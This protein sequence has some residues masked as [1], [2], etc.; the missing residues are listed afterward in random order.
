MAFGCT[1]TIFSGNSVPASGD[2]IFGRKLCTHKTHNWFSNNYSF[3]QSRILNS[4]KITSFFDRKKNNS[5]WLD[6]S[7]TAKSTTHQQRKEQHTNIMCVCTHKFTH[8]IQADRTHTFMCT[9][10]NV[11]ELYGKK[12]S[13]K[14]SRDVFVLY[15]VC[16]NCGVLVRMFRMTSCMTVCHLCRSKCVY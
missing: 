14:C 10:E 11:R 15:A 2:G 16:F 12:K 4:S 5:R 3:S 1:H 8:R 7:A 6:I 9:T 13:I